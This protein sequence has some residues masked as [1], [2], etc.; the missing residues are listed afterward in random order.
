MASHAQ[1]LVNRL[2]S[3][4]TPARKLFCVIVREA[5]HGPMRPKPPG[6]ATPAEILE[7]C[8]LDV[9]E[10]YS[11]LEVLKDQRL[12]EVSGDYPLEQIHL[13]PEAAAAEAIAEQCA[14]RSVSLEEVLAGLET[15]SLQ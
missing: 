12:I 6:V 13:T 9:G 2:G 5:Y 7:A 3:V 14:E 15:S 10:F 1:L 8:G 4:P 11:L